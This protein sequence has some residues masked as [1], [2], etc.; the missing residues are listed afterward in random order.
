M[1]KKI[2]WGALSVLAG[3]AA[4]FASPLFRGLTVQFKVYL[5]MCP[6]VVG[7]MVETDR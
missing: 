1:G 7:S 3:T 2:K 6:T 5:W 4:Y